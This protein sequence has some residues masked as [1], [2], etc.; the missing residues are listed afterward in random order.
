MTYEY[1]EAYC[2][3]CFDRLFTLLPDDFNGMRMENYQ[4]YKLK[5]YKKAG[6]TI[7]PGSGTTS[8]KRQ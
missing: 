4:D 7:V 8:Q 5:A 3:K 6:I 1:N 2:S